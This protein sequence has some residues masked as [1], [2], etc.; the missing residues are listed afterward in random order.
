[1][2]IPCMHDVF[3]EKADRETVLPQARCRGNSYVGLLLEV[4]AT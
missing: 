3:V 1:M 4:A 2:D